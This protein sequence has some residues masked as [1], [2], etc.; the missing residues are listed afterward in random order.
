MA[1]NYV[2]SAG[3]RRDYYDAAVAVRALVAADFEAVFASGVRG[4]EV[5]GFG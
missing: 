1:G 2:L 3:A 4:G 5:I